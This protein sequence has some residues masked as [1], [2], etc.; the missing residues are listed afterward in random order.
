MCFDWKLQ[1]VGV[2]EGSSSKIRLGTWLKPKAKS[3]FINLKRTV[4]FVVTLMGSNSIMPALDLWIGKQ[5]GH[6]VD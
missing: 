2:T 5:Y 4:Y 1:N 6:R 3:S